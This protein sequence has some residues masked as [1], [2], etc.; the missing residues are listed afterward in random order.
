MNLEKTFREIMGMEPSPPQPVVGLIEFQDNKGNQDFNCRKNLDDA[1]DII[2]HIRNNWDKENFNGVEA[3][4]MVDEF[5]DR[6][7]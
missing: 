3:D 1:K 5:M 2:Q 6:V 4:R 7:R